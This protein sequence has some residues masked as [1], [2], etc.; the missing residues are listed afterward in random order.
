MFY[1]VLSK[2]SCSTSD[3]EETK[4]VKE[5]KSDN[6]R[7]TPGCKQSANNLIHA[8]YLTVSH[9]LRTESI[10]HHI[11][12]RSKAKRV[13][14]IWDMLLR[15]PLWSKTR[16]SKH[17]D[18]E[19]CSNPD[20]HFPSAL[21]S[22]PHNGHGPAVKWSQWTSYQKHDHSWE[23]QTSNPIRTPSHFDCVFARV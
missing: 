15:I 21:L 4:R 2:Q 3:G 10:V 6:I 20:F 1:H 22:P 14:S 16:R 8:H 7:P 18:S 12:I 11:L 13:W 23:I 5:M 17:L 9:M 19:F